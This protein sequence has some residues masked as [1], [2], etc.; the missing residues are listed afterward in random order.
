MGRIFIIRPLP[1]DQN[2]IL[3]PDLEPRSSSNHGISFKY[4]PSLEPNAGSRICI[5]KQA[6]MIARLMPVGSD[7]NRH[8]TSTTGLDPLTGIFSKRNIAAI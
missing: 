8:V 7:V 4:I 6:I 1:A 3:F 5:T 2:N